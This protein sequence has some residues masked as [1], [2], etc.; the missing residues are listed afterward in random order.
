M[1]STKFI[2]SFVAGAAI[3]VVATWKVLEAKYEKIV[4]DEIQSVK[5]MYH[6]KMDRIEKINEMY[7][8]SAKN[9]SKALTD[10]EEHEKDV[11][12]YEDIVNTNYS[13]IS[14]QKNEKGGS[15]SMEK[16]YVISPDE[17][18]ELDGYTAISLKYY[19]NDILTDEDGEVI[20]DVENTVGIE[21]LDTFGEYEE[22]SV[23]VR[24][25]RLKCDYE[26]LKVEGDY[27]PIYED[28]E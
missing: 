4:Q 1:N 9:A 11:K 20:D 7:H 24:N 27:D 15:D 13:D 14:K 19:E 8:D 18:D 10:R 5:D 17:F 2:F 28:N 21:S 25:D 23:F 16:P 22:D 6:E 12:Q 26:I 3:G